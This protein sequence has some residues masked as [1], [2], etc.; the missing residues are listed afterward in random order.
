MTGINVQ[1]TVFFI[2]I[3]E[4]FHLYFLKS[5]VFKK[6]KKKKKLIIHQGL[7]KLDNQ[8]FE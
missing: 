1:I 3:L 7:V 2:R 4:V 8:E 6:F 5:H